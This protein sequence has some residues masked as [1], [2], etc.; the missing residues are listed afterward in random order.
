MN[1]LLKILCVIIF[2][3]AVVF[4]AEPNSVVESVTAEGN[5]IVVRYDSTGAVKSVQESSKQYKQAIKIDSIAPGSNSKDFIYS[6][7]KVVSKMTDN[8]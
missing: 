4:S 2:G 3:T 8:N 1:R 7:K 6:S 5:R